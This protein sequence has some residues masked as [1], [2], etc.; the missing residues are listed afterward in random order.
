MDIPANTIVINENRVEEQ[1]EDFPIFHECY[2]YE[3]HYKAFRLQKLTSSD[4]MVRSTVKSTVP[5]TRRRHA[6]QVAVVTARHGT[7]PA[8]VTL[9]HTHCV[10]SV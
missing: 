4:T 5:S 6:P 1:Y 9:K 8:S 7:E 10:W 3:K 2:H